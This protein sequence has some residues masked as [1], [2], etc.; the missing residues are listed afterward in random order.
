MKKHPNPSLIY[1][2]KEKMKGEEGEA[3]VYIY[4]VCGTGRIENT[5]KILH[6][7]SSYVVKRIDSFNKA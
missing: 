7:F 3:S 5:K 2:E 6:A 4:T 1:S